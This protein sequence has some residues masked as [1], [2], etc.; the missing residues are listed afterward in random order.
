M[1]WSK[2]VTFLFFKY[3]YFKLY[4]LY[5]S[6]KNKFEQYGFK[7]L[8]GISF[9]ILNNLFHFVILYLRAA[10]KD[11]IFIL[12]NLKELSFYNLNSTTQPTQPVQIQRSSSA[13][14]RF[15]FSYLLILT[16]NSCSFQVPVRLYSSQAGST[17]H[18][19]TMQGKT[20][21]YSLFQGVYQYSSSS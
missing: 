19:Q 1:F 2:N 18:R 17:I 10:N 15:S 11:M 12:T 6:H 9:K 7:I 20:G 16:V 8:V 5:N 14:S 4:G 3:N 21:R 13:M